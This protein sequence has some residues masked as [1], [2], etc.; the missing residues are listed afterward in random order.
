ML[1]TNFNSSKLTRFLAELDI[2]DAAEPGDAFAERLGQWL[3]VAD[4]ITLSAAQRLLPLAAG[5]SAAVGITDE[6]ER[7]RG[8]LVDSITASCSGASEAR[9]KLPLAKA[10]AGDALAAAYEPYRRFYVAQ[11]R[12]MEVAIRPL[13]GKAREVLASATPELKRLAALDAA[14]DGVL[15]E[16]EGRLLLT[17]PFLLEKRFAQL[18]QAAAAPADDAAPPGWLAVFCSELQTLLL[19]ELDLRLQPA[20]GLIEA[21][22]NEVTETNE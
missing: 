18:A 22:S 9:I 16:R 1:R 19:A 5:Q 15:A 6:F 4:A 12:D 14:L 17:V 10:V 11:Q 20:L 7:V 8:V 3:G 2:V 21:F 13:R